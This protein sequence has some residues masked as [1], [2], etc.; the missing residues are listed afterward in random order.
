MPQL[1]V[2]RNNVL[3]LTVLAAVVV[4]IALVLR[5]A[6]SPLPG[7]YNIWVAGVGSVGCG[8]DVHVHTHLITFKRCKN[9]ALEMMR[10]SGHYWLT[11]LVPAPPPSSSTQSSAPA[12]AFIPTPWTITPPI[13]ARL[14]QT[15]AGRPLHTA[16]AA[17]PTD[18]APRSAPAPTP[19]PG[20]T[21]ILP[22]ATGCALPPGFTPDPG[23]SNVPPPANALPPGVIL[24]PG[25]SNVPP[26]ANALPPGFTPDPPGFTPDPQQPPPHAAAQGSPTPSDQGPGNTPQIPGWTREIPPSTTQG[27]PVSSDQGLGGWTRVIPPSTTQGSP[28][29]SDQGLGGWT[30]EVPPPAQIPQPPPH[31]AAQLAVPWYERAWARV[32]QDAHAVGQDISEGVTALD[33]NVAPGIVTVPTNPTQVLQQ[34]P[35][36]HGIATRLLGPETGLGIDPFVPWLGSGGIPTRSVRTAIQDVE[37]LTTPLNIALAA[38]VWIG[39]SCAK[40]KF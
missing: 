31:A 19:V 8:M 13:G 29:S 38:L 33:A 17:V 30:R 36:I 9:G 3:R 25:Q 10:G 7:R 14:E 28:A 21:E 18:C 23:E 24:D 12:A 35:I 39:Y 16:S 11:Q 15:S 4:V 20:W 22:P 26:P 34:G 1:T 32:E 5:L 40:Q 6:L 27:S 37:G 2:T